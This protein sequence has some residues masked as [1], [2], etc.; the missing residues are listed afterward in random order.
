[1]TT[2]MLI[3]FISYKGMF[4]VRSQSLIGFVIKLRMLNLHTERVADIALAEPEEMTRRDFATLVNPVRLGALCATDICF[5]YGDSEPFVLNGLSLSVSPG[6]SLAIT[7]ASGSGKTT[8][9]RIRRAEP[10]ASAGKIS[11]RWV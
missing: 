1:M 3:A 9:L 10:S 7:G 6:E 2:G 5:R 8:V 4:I 11:G